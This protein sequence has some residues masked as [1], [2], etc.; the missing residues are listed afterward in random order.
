MWPSEERFLLARARDDL[1]SHAKNM[2]RAKN[3]AEELTRWK[4]DNREARITLIG[5][6]GGAAVALWACEMLPPDVRVNKIVLLSAAVSPGYDLS[7]ALSRCDV[8]IFNYYSGRDTYFLDH[9][10]KRW[11]TMDRKYGPAAGYRGFD[12]PENARN[13]TKLFQRAWD[14]SMIW[15]GNFGGHFGFT[16]EGFERKVIAP[17]LQEDDVPSGWSHS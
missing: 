7:K 5:V 17:L 13:R 10:T 12:S 8:G 2:R 15:Q 1:Q 14:E 11:G 3:L 16:G 9:E 4:R 6:S